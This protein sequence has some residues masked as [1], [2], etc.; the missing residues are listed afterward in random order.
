MR[1]AEDHG[2]RQ[3]HNDGLEDGRHLRMR[4]HAD[5]RRPHNGWYARLINVGK[6]VRPDR[7]S[8]GSFLVYYRIDA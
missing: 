7:C 2:P 5:P 8:N 3:Q 1:Q 6:H 4:I